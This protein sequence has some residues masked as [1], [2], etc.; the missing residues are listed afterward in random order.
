MPAAAKRICSHQGCHALTSDKSGRCER[1]PRKQWAK[2]Q[3]RE[4]STTE[5]GYGWAWQ[6]LRA[7]ILQRDS[8]LCQ[9][10]LAEGRIES[11]TEVD[12]IINK[13]T[14]D[15]LH[16]TPAGVDDHTNLQSLCKACHKAKTEAEARRGRGD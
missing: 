2:A 11:A 13:A 1:H 6:K 7:Q 10:G 15:A 3:G 5:R 4:G 14:W 16:G 12:H 8:Y 9:A